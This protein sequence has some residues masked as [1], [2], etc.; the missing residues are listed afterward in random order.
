MTVPYANCPKCGVRYSKLV[1]HRCF[2]PEEQKEKPEFDDP[3]P[4]EE[5]EDGGEGGKPEEKDGQGEPREGEGEGQGEGEQEGEG[6]GEGEGED[7]DEQKGQGEAP[8][9]QM[10]EPE[11]PPVAVVCTVLKFAALTAQCAT[12][13]IE[14]R[15]KEDGLEVYGHNGEAYGFRIIPWG[16]FEKRSTL[17]GEFYVKEVIDELDEELS[18]EVIEGV[19]TEIEPED[20]DDGWIE[21]GGGVNPLA[22]GI[23]IVAR[24]RNG[25]TT[26]DK[27]AFPSK[28]WDWSHTGGPQDIVAYRIVR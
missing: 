5:G 27:Y 7:E 6:D 2:R 15:L 13:L 25:T 16:E 26:E 28:D 4:G 24:F 14:V 22:D 21:W 20:E 8:E 17:D 18:G 11:T 19:A 10:P 1:K 3:P 12:A 23:K 9:P